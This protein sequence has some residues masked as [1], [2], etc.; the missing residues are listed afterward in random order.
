MRRLNL[1]A[2]TV[3]AILMVLSF[4]ALFLPPGCLNPF[5]AVVNSLVTPPAVAANRILRYFSSSQDPLPPAASAQTRELLDRI[6]LLERQNAFLH[7]QWMRMADIY[8]RSEC[9]HKNLLLKNYSLIHANVCG[10]NLPG[11]AVISIDQGSTAGLEV[12]FWVVGFPHTTTK[13][14]GRALLESSV[15]LGRLTGVQPR[16]AQ[17]RL[18]GDPDYPPISAKI[19][20]RLSSTAQL[21]PD[22][23]SSILHVQSLPGGLLIAKDVPN[24]TITHD[25]KLADA[26][27]ARIITGQSMKDLP[28]GLTIGRVIK[29]EASPRSM[30]FSDLTIEPFAR[31]ARLSYVMVLR[32]QRSGD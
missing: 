8:A 1:S 32:P 20:R 31:T 2:S 29:V 11:R 14:T 12:G 3:F 6:R 9:L 26:L 4:L 25:D 24:E 23:I 30:L 27:G 18:L 22:A 5:R 10:Y 7:S 16:T 15:L 13:L 17:V 21:Q 28:A 19:D